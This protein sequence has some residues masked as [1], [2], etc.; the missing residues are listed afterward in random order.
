MKREW[1]KVL[2]LVVGVT[3]LVVLYWTRTWTRIP[4][5][6][7]LLIL[8]YSVGVALITLAG[9]IYYF[10]RKRTDWDYGFRPYIKT[11]RKAIVQ[12]SWPLLLTGGVCFLLVGAYVQRNGATASLGNIASILGWLVG[13]L[14]LIPSMWSLWNTIVIMNRQERR[15]DNYDSLLAVVCRDLEELTKSIECA[16]DDE[17]AT[18][19]IF[20]PSPAIGNLSASLKSFDRF[21]NQLRDSKTQF[22]I[23][24]RMLVLKEFS[25]WH[26]TYIDAR[27]ELIKSA[28]KSRLPIAVK[29]ARQQLSKHFAPEW[30][31]VVV[32]AQTKFDDL[33]AQVREKVNALDK[34]LG[35]HSDTP[36]NPADFDDHLLFLKRLAHAAADAYALRILGHFSDKTDISLLQGTPRDFPPIVALL[37]G[38]RVSLTWIA[39][40]DLENPTENRLLGY[41]SDEADHRDILDA[42]FD[43][44]KADISEGPP[45]VEV[46]PNGTLPPIKSLPI[47]DIL[48]A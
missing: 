22:K 25:A 11:Y 18:L 38:E 39:K 8:W 7:A 2:L 10:F 34:A 48:T 21:Y 27:I 42:L 44:Y 5:A 29:K 35:S 36:V 1:R 26:E 16:D 23:T 9:C 14:A 19:W 4:S 43:K 15:I 13:L 41:T 24:P 12:S 3:L 47:A 45:K 31:R 30:F 20:A 32:E 37:I 17:P 6:S 33:R 46:Y 40:T 28:L